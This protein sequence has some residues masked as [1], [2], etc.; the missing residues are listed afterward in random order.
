MQILDEPFYCCQMLEKNTSHGNF[1]VR[2]CKQK[3]I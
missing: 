3:V 1:A 2:L